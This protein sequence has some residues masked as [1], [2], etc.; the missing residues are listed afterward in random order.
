MAPRFIKYLSYFQGPSRSEEEEDLQEVHL[1]RGG[2]RSTSRHELRATNG[3]DG[4][5]R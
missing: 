5:S 1:S 4:Q 2:L 3:I